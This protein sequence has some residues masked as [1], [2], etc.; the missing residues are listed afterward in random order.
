MKTPEQDFWEKKLKTLGLGADI[1]TEAEKAAKAGIEVISSDTLGD[2]YKTLSL[3]LQEEDP[4]NVF[5]GFPGSMDV[6]I[7]LINTLKTEWLEQGVPPQDIN[8]AVHSS[9]VND[10]DCVVVSQNGGK[11]YHY[12]AGN[13]TEYSR[14]KLIKELTRRQ[15]PFREI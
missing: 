9:C 3:V 7:S 11:K 8:I 5:A 4:R 14:G 15:I 1:K 13:I 10:K 2:T 6:L 12:N